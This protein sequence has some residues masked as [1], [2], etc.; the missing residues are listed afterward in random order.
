LDSTFAA[1]FADAVSNWVSAPSFSPML[2]ALIAESCFS[3]VTAESVFGT[4]FIP[5]VYQL[6]DSRNPL[7]VRFGVR[8]FKEIWDAGLITSEFFIEPTSMEAFVQE[9]LVLKYNR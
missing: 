5:I 9:R 4:R 8:A 1:R 6:L 3:S 2:F 7:I